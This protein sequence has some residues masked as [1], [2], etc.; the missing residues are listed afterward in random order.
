MFVIKVH[1]K[2]QCLLYVLISFCL[3]RGDRV[4]CLVSL[5]D[6]ANWAC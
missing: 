6:E 5:R 2:N 3:L 1:L 4:K